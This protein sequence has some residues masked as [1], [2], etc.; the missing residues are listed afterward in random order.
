MKTL[1]DKFSGYKGCTLTSFTWLPDEAPRAGLIIVH[2]AG[3]HAGRYQN[4]VNPLVPAGIA[5]FSYDERGHGRSDGQRSHIDAWDEYRE[6]LH[7][8]TDRI[9][10]ANPSLPLFLY[11]H[12]MGAA[13]VLDF[14]QY[15]PAY[16]PG[17][18]V[19]G[20][21]LVP[22]QAATP[23]L[24][25]VAKVMSNVWP[26]Y[27]SKSPSLSAGL[28]RDTQVGKAYDSDPLVFRERTARWA[29]EILSVNENI[30]KKAGDI[31]LP[32][33]FIHGS[34]DPLVSAQGSKSF[35]EQVGSK[36]KTFH[37]YQGS[38]HEVH[39]DLEHERVAADIEE[40]IF[41]HIR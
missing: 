39:N 29:T 33:L 27:V 35:F 23:L 7:I 19:S 16:F 4:L 8:F 37:L 18:I 38:Y 21:P 12:S 26:R 20:V 3:E 5:I 17:V 2:G 15:Y 1:T 9:R 40:W 24:I 36:D 22:L 11:G 31:R 6:D 30:K 28:S 34:E 13:T 14:I 25:M 41:Q 10:A 32:I